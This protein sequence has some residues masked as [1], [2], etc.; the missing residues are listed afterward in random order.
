MKRVLDRVSTSED[1]EVLKIVPVW[2]KNLERADRHLDQIEKDKTKS[3]I[4][5]DSRREVSGKYYMLT[6]SCV[7]II[8][9]DLSQNESEKDDE[10]REKEEP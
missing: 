8:P 10:W 1:P 9:S 5:L 3:F 2:A 4:D 7:E 6:A